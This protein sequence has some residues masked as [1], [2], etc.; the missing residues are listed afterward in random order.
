MPPLAQGYS[1]LTYDRLG[2]GNS[3]KPDVYDIIQVSV[4]IE[5]LRGLT[6]LAPRRQPD[7]RSKEGRPATPRS[8]PTSPS[9]SCT[10]ATSFGSHP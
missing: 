6:N 10:S 8:E 9:R 4:E 2:T 1:I 5:I 7:Q 3:A